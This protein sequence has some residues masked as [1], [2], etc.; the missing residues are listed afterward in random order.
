[1]EYSLSLVQPVLYLSVFASL[2]VWLVYVIK[3]AVDD[4]VVRE[5]Q[6]KHQE[7]GTICFQALVALGVVVYLFRGHQ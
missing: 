5:E 1:M 2:V 6:L 3:Y 4:T 7:R